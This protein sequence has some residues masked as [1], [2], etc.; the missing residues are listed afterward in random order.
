M[1]LFLSCCKSKRFYW[2]ENGKSINYDISNR[3]RRQDF[4]GSLVENGLFILIL[5][6]I[7]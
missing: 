4:N 1:I 6:K 7:L 2:D 3:P 5:L